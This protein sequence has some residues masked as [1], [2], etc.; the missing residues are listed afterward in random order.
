M[1]RWSSHPGKRGQAGD[2]GLVS[3]L[4]P[5][6]KEESGHENRQEII[7]VVFWNTRYVLVNDPMEGFCE[8]IK[9]VRGRFKTK[10]QNYCMIEEAL[11]FKVRSCQSTG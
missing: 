7:Q 5:G 10:G 8:E 9:D 4:L 11:P 6:W 3:S 1:G 2:L